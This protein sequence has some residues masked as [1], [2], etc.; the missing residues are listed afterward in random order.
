MVFAESNG[1]GKT[2]AEHIANISHEELKEKPGTI[3]LEVVA[4][5]VELKGSEECR[6]HSKRYNEGM[7]RR[8][9][10]YR[11]PFV[12]AFDIGITAD[13]SQ[14]QQREPQVVHCLNVD[15]EHGDAE[16]RNQTKRE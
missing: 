1:Q 13:A 5:G 10:D 2:I 14:W 12:C 4:F 15:G 6:Q 9:D 8:D 16:R 11:Q 7:S 3:L